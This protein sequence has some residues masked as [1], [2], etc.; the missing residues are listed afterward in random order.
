MKK[1][2]ALLGFYD[3]FQVILEEMD[4]FEA[5]E[6]MEELNAQLED[7]LFLMENIDEDEAD[8]AEEIQGVIE[9]LEDLLGEYKDLAQVRPEIAQKVMELEMAVQMAR[10]NLI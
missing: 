9:E 6:A 8:A 7:V 10:R 4:A 5:D 1:N 3:R 2:S